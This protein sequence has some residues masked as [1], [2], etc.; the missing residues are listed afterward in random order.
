MLDNK[1]MLNIEY[2]LLNYDYNVYNILRINV[3]IIW[4]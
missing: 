2:I 4:L 1:D 3:N